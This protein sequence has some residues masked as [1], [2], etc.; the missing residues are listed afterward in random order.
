LESEGKP[1][2][3]DQKRVTRGRAPVDADR[4]TGEGSVLIDGSAGLIHSHATITGDGQ[5]VGAGFDWGLP[6]FQGVNVYLHR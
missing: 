5:N 3:G 6:F 1:E 4:C 2:I